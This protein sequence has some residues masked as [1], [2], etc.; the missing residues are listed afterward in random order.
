[1]YSDMYYGIISV[2]IIL[3]VCHLPVTYYYGLLLWFALVMHVYISII[4][5][6]V[7]CLLQQNKSNKKQ[8]NQRNIFTFLHVIGI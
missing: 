2:I 6:L 5:L 4:V 1:M 7:I 3:D 8:P